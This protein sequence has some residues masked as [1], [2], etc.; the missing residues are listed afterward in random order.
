MFGIAGG[1]KGRKHAWV[2]E[3]EVEVLI[4]GAFDDKELAEMFA[5]FAEG[6]GSF[7]EDAP[8]FVAHGFEKPGSERVVGFEADQIGGDFLDVV[9]EVA[10]VE[11]A[12]VGIVLLQHGEEVVAGGPVDD[13]VGGQGWVAVAGKED[14]P[15]WAG[16]LGGSGG[17]AEKGFV[18]KIN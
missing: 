4:F 7:A 16:L 15:E 14:F 13:G 2:V 17:H 9:I 12:V 5:E 6:G 11:A 3:A 10:D 18:R 8:G 1:K